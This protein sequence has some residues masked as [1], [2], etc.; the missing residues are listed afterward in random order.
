[1]SETLKKTDS[2]TLRTKKSDPVQKVKDFLFANPSS[3]TKSQTLLVFAAVLGLNA[4]LGLLLP[5]LATGFWGAGFNTQNATTDIF[6]AF[7]IALAVLAFLC[8]KSQTQ[9]ES[10]EFNRSKEEQESRKE[11]KK[12][13]GSTCKEEGERREKSIQ[14]NN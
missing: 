13:I 12:E 2:S 10:R 9:K 1:M 3:T 4:V 7:S 5:G 14:S 6:R 8:F 11:R